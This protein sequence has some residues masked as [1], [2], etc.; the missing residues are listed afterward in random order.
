MREWATAKLKTQMLKTT[1][2][3][4]LQSNGNCVSKFR[5]IA[6]SCVENNSDANVKSMYTIMFGEYKGINSAWSM[7]WEWEYMEQNDR[8]YMKEATKDGDE[9]IGCYQKQITISKIAQVNNFKK[10]LSG[11]D[12]DERPKGF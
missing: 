5:D 2:S 4:H 7:N 1:H 9:M 10:R 6:K 3:L 12:S 8:E 11:Q